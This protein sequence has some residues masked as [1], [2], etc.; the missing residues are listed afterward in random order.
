[1]NK[2]VTLNQKE[3]CGISGGMCLCYEHKGFTGP[4]SETNPSL[5]TCKHRCCRDLENK[6]STNKAWQYSDFITH[7]PAREKN[8]RGLCNSHKKEHTGK[9]LFKIEL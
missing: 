7:G 1:M 3:C 8:A 6:P 9:S 2:A 5:D 4:G